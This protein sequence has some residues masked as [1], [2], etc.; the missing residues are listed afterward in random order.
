MLYRAIVEVSEV[1]SRLAATFGCSPCE[2]STGFLGEYE[3]LYFCSGRLYFPRA[4]S[5]R[6]KVQ[7]AN[8]AAQSRPS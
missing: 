3:G 1:A 4:M 6:E 5:M 8:M 2:A 7:L